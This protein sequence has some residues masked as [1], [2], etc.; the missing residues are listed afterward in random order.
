MG[1]LLR[2]ALVAAAPLACLQ[3]ADAGFVYQSA[4]RSVSASL[5]SNSDS[6]ST[7]AFGL[8]FDSAS[9]FAGGAAASANHGSD[10]LV[11]EM[12]FS[13]GAQVF[14]G[15]NG[16]ASALSEADITFL[17]M[18]DDGASFVDVEWL[19]GLS[20][21]ASGSTTSSVW[22]TLTDVTSG[23]VL[24][25]VAGNS[26][27]SSPL[28]LSSGGLYRLQIVSS[29]N[30]TSSGNALANYNVSFSVIPAPGALSLLALSGFVALRRR[31]ST[32]PTAAKAA[33]RH[34]SVS[35][36]ETA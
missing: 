16:G 9:V 20:E 19:V 32:P 36:D 26:V 6:G 5:A 29:A 22:F 8:W 15:A 10:L 25:S 28:V 33:A 21:S 4:Q 27:S 17:A 2:S 14:S 18:S 11:D 3:A 35:G 23:V 24:V 1:S 30:G 13:G 34:S 31:R 7:S 12:T